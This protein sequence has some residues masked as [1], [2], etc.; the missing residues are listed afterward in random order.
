MFGQD[1]S[2][3][4]IEQGVGHQQGGANAQGK[5]HHHGQAEDGIQRQRHQMNGSNALQMKVLMQPVA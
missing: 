3:V 5:H 2:Q 4:S 1:F